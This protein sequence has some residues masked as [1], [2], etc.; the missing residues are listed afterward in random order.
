MKHERGT[1]GWMGLEFVM[2][3]YPGY[4]FAFPAHNTLPKFPCM[5]LQNALSIV[6]ALHTVVSDQGTHL[7]TSEVQQKACACVIHWSCHVPHLPEGNGLI[8]WQN[9]QEAM[10]CRAAAMSSVV[11]CML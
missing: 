1:E 8:G 10:P 7:T 9:D 11:L 2:V 4:G 3:S 5:D 6:T